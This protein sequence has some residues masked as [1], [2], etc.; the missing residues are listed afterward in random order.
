MN[1]LACRV[2]A[3]SI[4]LSAAAPCL[5]QDDKGLVR[6]PLSESKILIERDVKAPGR[7][8][9]DKAFGSGVIAPQRESTEDSVR[10]LAPK[11][12]LVSKYS[13]GSKQSAELPP[14]KSRIIRLVGGDATAVINGASREMEEGDVVTVGKRDTLVIKTRKDTA[15]LEVTEIE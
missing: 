15:L 5:A 9:A 12:V 4:A 10:V 2:V 7:V 1:R 11:T 14:G 3:I 8:P 6:R 13:L